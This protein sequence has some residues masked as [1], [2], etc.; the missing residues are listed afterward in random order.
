MEKNRDQFRDPRAIRK[1]QRTITL[2]DGTRHQVTI[3]IYPPGYP[4]GIG[5][6]WGRFKRGRS[7]KGKMK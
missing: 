4:N 2:S 1:E 3:E 6:T 5:Q 7:M